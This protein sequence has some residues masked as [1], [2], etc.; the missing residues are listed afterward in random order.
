MDNE[1]KLDNVEFWIVKVFG[2]SYAHKLLHPWVTM[3][4]N[5]GQSE[6][7]RDRVSDWFSDWVSEGQVGS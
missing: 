6:W 5:E 4:L 1:K 3:R 7:M 2:I